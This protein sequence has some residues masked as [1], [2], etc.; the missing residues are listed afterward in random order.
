[1]RNSLPLFGIGRLIKSGRFDIRSR[2]YS[3]ISPRIAVI[4]SGPAG[5]YLTSAVLRRS[6]ESVI[7]VFD[8]SPVPFGLVRYGVAPD[9]PEVKNCT[10]QFDKL[11]NEN[12]HRLSL[13]C[14]VGVGTDLSFGE[15]RS[16]YDVVALAY[17][18]NR[19]RRLNIPGIYGA[20]NCYSGSDFV[21]WYNGLP[22]ARHPKLDCEN[23][24]IV[25]NGNV[26][27][28]CARILLS[29]QE[30]LAKTDVPEAILNEF[31]GSNV[32]NVHIVGRRGPLDISFT[33]KELREQIKL[34][35]SSFS[36][37]M[38]SKQEIDTLLEK[39]SSL[40]RPK[41]RVTELLLKNA[42]PD[43]QY[44]KQCR[45]LFH[46]KP[47]GVLKDSVGRVSAVEFIDSR[48]NEIIQLPCGLLI[49][50]IGFENIIL[51]GVPKTEDGSAILMKDFCRVDTEKDSGA[52]VYA[53]G[54]CANKPQ[55][56][57]ANTQNS[58]VAV[59]QEICADL[60]AS[61]SE[62]PKLSGGIEELL[63]ERGVSYVTWEQWKRIDE[64]ERLIGQTSGKDREKVMDFNV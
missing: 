13:Y 25:G 39:A 29:T 61:S 62:K 26:A 12:R 11:F 51:D 40:Q 32:S 9:H 64:K 44:S 22:G 38:I 34:P 17:G 6:K 42:F 35:G 20:E 8:K 27:L 19:P 55:G 49:Y 31:G 54:W 30:R 46:N 24:V 7:D 36:I 58:A 23:A 5:L 18:A 56:V 2:W 21:S 47:T 28:D 48:T 10:H 50:S 14:N 4:G 43:G 57:I 60:E 52:S 59:A 3:H 15:L 45:L 33:I 53:V 16:R 63:T 37:D 1:M 41:R